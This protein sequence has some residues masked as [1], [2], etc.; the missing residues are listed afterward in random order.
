MPDR[1]PLRLG[2]IGLGQASYQIIYP[3]SRAAKGLPLDSGRGRR[4]ASARLR[5]VSR[6]SS[7]RRGSLADAADLCRRANVDAVYIATPSW[8]HLE[9]ATVAAEN[10][11]HII[12]EKPLALSLEDCDRMVAVA[13][14]SM[15]S[16]FPWL[17]IP[18]SF[19]A[20]IRAIK[21]LVMGGE[22]GRPACAQQLELQRV[23][24]PFPAR[25]GARRHPRTAVQSG[26]TSDRHHPPDRGRDGE[27]GARIHGRR[28]GHRNRGRLCGLA[29]IRE[30]R[31]G[32][33][34]LRRPRA[35]RHR[36]AVLVAR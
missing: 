31:R 24:P 9:H 7:G 18:Y 25:H 4:S 6:R 21:M 16:S 5:G 13:R 29:G 3:R 32:D 11:K 26:A 36:R 2:I 33:R 20:P 27:I 23:Q 22:Y 28:R 34:G 12:C 15:A 8:M 17:A 1:K 35:V 30:R 14:A 10:H 19:D